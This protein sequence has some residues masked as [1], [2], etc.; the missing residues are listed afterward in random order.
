[1]VDYN[2]YT[3]GPDDLKDANLVGIADHHKLGGLITSA[4]LE[5]W[6]RPVGCSNT[7]IKEMFD[8]YECRDSKRYRWGY[9]VCN[10]K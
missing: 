9:D 1:M 10:F 6:I 2:N 7:V 5:V 8:Y 3:E 4:P